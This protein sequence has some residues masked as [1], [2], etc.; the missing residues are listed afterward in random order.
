MMVS[1]G[2]AACL[3]TH[4]GVIAPGEVCITCT[5][6]NFKKSTVRTIFVFQVF[7]SGE[8]IRFRVTGNGFLHNMVRIM[9]GTLIEIGRG[10]RSGVTDLFGKKREEAGFLVPGKGLCLEEVVY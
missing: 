10:E 9:V 8:E 7:R 5:N 3:G 1:P 4:E 6:R 2:C